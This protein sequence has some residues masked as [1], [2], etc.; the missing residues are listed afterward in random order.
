MRRRFGNFWR[1]TA[2]LFLTL[3][4]WGA[5][6]VN[7]QGFSKKWRNY[8]NREFRKHGFEVAIQ[9]LT[10]DPF[11]GLVARNVQVYSYG[12]ASRPTGEINEV[13][14][15]VD[16]TR[17]L[18]GK[19]FLNAIDL[20]RSEIK[21]PVA[22]DGPPVIIQDLSARV[23]LPEGEVILRELEATILGVRI[24]ADGRLMTDAPGDRDTG[25]GDDDRSK[26][27]D[28]SPDPDSVPKDAEA[29]LRQGIAQWWPMLRTE[30]LRYEVT[31]RKPVRLKIGFH[32][33]LDQLDDMEVNAHLEGRDLLRDG[34]A[35]RH[36]EVQARYANQRLT[37]KN[38]MLESA[39]GQ[40]KANAVLE[41]GQSAGGRFQVY[42]KFNFLPVLQPLLP[43]DSVLRDI[44]L[45]TPPEIAV[46]GSIRQVEGKLVPELVGKLG[47][48]D[49]VFRG[50]QFEHLEADFALNG[51]RWMVQGL[52]LVHAS[53]RLTGS[54]RVLPE[55]VRAELESTLSPRAVASVLGGEGLQRALGEI[56]FTR[57]P[58]IRL[59]MEGKALGTSNVVTR[60]SLNLPRFRYRG[61][62]FES[63]RGQLTYRQ[64][65]TT[66]E[67]VVLD[68]P[69]GSIR[70]NAQVN[71]EYQ[72]ALDKAK[73]TI[74][75][76]ELVRI[77][78]NMLE[79]SLQPYRLRGNPTVTAD[80]YV[81]LRPGGPSNLR[82]EIDAPAGLD[83]SLF[84]KVLPAETASAQVAYRDGRLEIPELEA[85]L[86]GGQLALSLFIDF[87][88]QRAMGGK[89]SVDGVDY[90]R[91][92]HLF[93][94]N[95][96]I[97]GILK[98]RSTFEARVGDLRTL[99][100]KG[101]AEVIS[102]NVFNMSFLGPLSGLLDNTI[103]FGASKARSFKMAFDM[104]EGRVKSDSIQILTSGYALMGTGTYDLVDNSLD[105]TMRA[106]MR[107]GPGLLLYPVSKLLE[108]SASG[109]LK[110]PQ[111][112]AKN[113][114][115]APRDG[116]DARRG[117]PPPRAIP[118]NPPEANPPREESRNPP[119]R[120]KPT[121]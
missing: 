50:E 99:A 39:Q 20:R 19:D 91:L 56:E 9:R 76:G 42:G 46:S 14:L 5:W 106:N 21:I 11:R 41:A 96:E 107:G 25:D 88:N 18:Q 102:Q 81:S 65:V 93:T 97:E 13:A 71:T 60:G 45:Q 61:V 73:S 58:E 92:G 29:E 101:E 22:D 8:I 87:R 83:A 16:Y 64:G 15:D 113:F 24:T 44:S 26:K 57:S 89:V 103:G 82:L 40:L 80:G 75:A 63:G 32:G 49:P 31:G 10:L 30:L 68:R 78:G 74:N 119:R 59:R 94:G 114:T 62:W 37:I 27:T 38:A 23:S 1:V 3:L 98:G 54:M 121:R 33:H 118:V 105:A 53:G 52:K 120:N 17:F 117:D 108:F 109:T 36:V 55:D 111:W 34:E 28:D 77:L 35:V 86:F 51:S 115:R 110:E 47:S 2:A 116:D 43:K 4:L 6:F 67:N 84:G 112:R 70:G 7:T 12:D 48:A 104:E 90:A 69:E 100:G 95:E 85:E 66:L 72:L 79:R